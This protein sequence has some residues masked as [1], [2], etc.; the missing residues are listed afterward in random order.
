M[1][2]KVNMKS[3][4][5]EIWTRLKEITSQ[6]NMVKKENLDLLKK[7]K[8]V[9]KVDNNASVKLGQL[10]NAIG[11]INY[12]KSVYDNLSKVNEAIDFKK[13]QLKELTD[14]EY[15]VNTLEALIQSNKEAKIDHDRLIKELNTN[16]EDKEKLLE[17]KYSR[18][19]EEYQYIYDR[20]KLIKNNELDDE[21][22]ERRKVIQE[23]E[24][25]LT[26]QVEEFREKENKFNELETEIKQ[27]KEGNELLL[28]TKIKA[29]LAKQ[30]AILEKDFKHQLEIKDITHKAENE[31]LEANLLILNESVRNSKENYSSLVEKLEA[32]YKQIE[33]I[34]N[35]S[36]EAS[37]QKESFNEMKKILN[38][39]KG[40][41]KQ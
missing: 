25:A 10:E 12:I 37:S 21:I 24:K 18:K 35:K 7:N 20:N 14:I 33:A 30:K 22:E 27:L 11:T 41:E 36:V 40:V 3:T 28:N 15:E 9:S 26:K 19:A 1:E 17:T 31:R 23:E 4:K 13:D 32:A 5:D 39:I 16:F 6:L 29:E 8:E 38:N 34:A 2:K